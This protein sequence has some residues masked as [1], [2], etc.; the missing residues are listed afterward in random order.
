MQCGGCPFPFD[1]YWLPFSNDC[2]SLSFFF[3]FDVYFITYLQYAF[4]LPAY[5][6]VF[7]KCGA[8]RKHYKTLW[9]Y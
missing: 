4:S 1:V 7:S 5:G 3:K 2:N 8:K 9:E 6:E